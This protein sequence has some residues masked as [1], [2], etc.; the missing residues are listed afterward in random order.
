MRTPGPWETST[1]KL[2]NKVEWDICGSDGGDIIADLMGCENAKANAAFI[3]RA[4]N[5]HDD[6]MEA[7]HQ[8][9]AALD[10]RILNASKGASV[11]EALEKIKQAISK[12]EGREGK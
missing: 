9:W 4:C 10:E 12:A 8:M 3:V 7:C 6:L 1:I 11:K 5:A 2:A